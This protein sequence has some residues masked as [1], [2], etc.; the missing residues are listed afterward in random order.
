MLAFS[1][2]MTLA[3][4]ALAPSGTGTIGTG[5]YERWWCERPFDQ[6]TLSMIPRKRIGKA[7]V[8]SITSP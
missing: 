1:G 5:H 8:V 2:P 6:P 4:S 3:L 7:R